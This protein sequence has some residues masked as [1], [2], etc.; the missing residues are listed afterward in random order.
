MKKFLK[1]LFVFGLIT[2]F[3]SCN[4]SFNYKENETIVTKTQDLHQS[5]ILTSNNLGAVKGIIQTE[6]PTD[7]I[8]LIL[9]LGQIISDSNGMYGGYL[10]PEIAPVAI[11]DSNNGEFVFVDIEPGEYSL[12]IHEVVF[13]GQA[14]MDETGSVEIITVEQGL[15]T[16]LG[17]IP[18][19]GF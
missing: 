12:I 7:R 15:I 11:Y 19:N 5:I 16:D 4:S 3:S 13:G 9:Y 18:F 10:N 2:T 1:W 8:G 6:E 14:Y 17:I